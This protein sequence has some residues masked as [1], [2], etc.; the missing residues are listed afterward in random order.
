M[1]RASSTVIR[2]P[3]IFWSTKI[4]RR[5]AFESAIWIGAWAGRLSKHDRIETVQLIQAVLKEDLSSIRRS[6]K[7]LANGASLDSS[8]QRQKFRKLVLNMM[9]SQEFAGL[10][11]IR[12][13]FNLLEQLTFEGFVF[14]ADLMFFRK[15]IFTLEGVINDLWPSFDMDAAVM[16]YLLTLMTAE[17]PKRLANLLFPLADK[18]ENYPSLISNNEL[19]SLIVHQYIAAVRSST[20]SYAGSLTGWS[21]MFGMPFWPAVAPIPLS[22][23]IKK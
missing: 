20:Q 4:P 13:T 22:D 2:T 17:I 12:K 19:Q 11:L 1:S 15:A 6:V 16:Q 5:I 23:D 7:A 18:P 3:A 21:R 10:T 14:P 9:R 8:G